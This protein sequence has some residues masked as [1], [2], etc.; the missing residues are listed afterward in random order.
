MQESLFQEQPKETT[1]ETELEK[2]TEGVKHGESGSGSSSAAPAV[3]PA[4]T[5]LSRH[6][7]TLQVCTWGQLAG[8]STHLSRSSINRPG[9]GECRLPAPPHI[10]L[11]TC[12]GSG[13]RAGAPTLPRQRQ[14]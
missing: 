5:A 8:I 10:G 13:M 3:R 2:W 12:L 14:S 1:G 7:E 11:G 9:C 4:C 6:K